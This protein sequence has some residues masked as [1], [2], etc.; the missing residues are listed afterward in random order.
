MESA[1]SN[2]RS[3]HSPVPGCQ[4]QAFSYVRTALQGCVSQVLPMLPVID[5]PVVVPG[6]LTVEGDLF[7]NEGVAIHNALLAGEQTS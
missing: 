3:V 4:F 5:L 2:N 6:E 1:Y 7:L